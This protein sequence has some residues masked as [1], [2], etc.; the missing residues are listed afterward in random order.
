MQIL[1][2]QERIYQEW[3]GAQLRNT[4]W[5]DLIFTRPIANWLKNEENFAVQNNCKRDAWKPANQASQSNRKWYG[6]MRHGRRVTSPGLHLFG[7]P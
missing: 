1:E 2:R 5:V 6:E 4:D 3:M 7:A